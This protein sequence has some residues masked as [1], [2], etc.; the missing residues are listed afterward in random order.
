MKKCI[1]CLGSGGIRGFTHIGVL[2]ALQEH[3][4][5]V[6][7]YFGTSVGSLV[8]AFAA[9]GLSAL[10]IEKK[11]LS[12]KP[13]QLLDLTFPKNGFIKGEKLKTYIEE[14]VSQKNIE[15]LKIPVRIIATNSKTGTAVIFKSGLISERVQASCAIPNIFRPTQIDGVEYLDGDLKSPVPMLMA[16]DEFKNE[17]IVGVN[18]IARTDQA[19]RNHRKWS[20]WVAKDMYRRSLVDH[21]KSAADIYMDIDIGYFGHIMGDWPSRQIE[22]GYQETLKIIPKLKQ[23]LVID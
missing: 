23:L 20:R 12:I 18:I 22:I 8:S 21:E 15:D 11:A 6:Q 14:N 2:K 16:R 9:S 17:I 1:L 4:I 19:P 10:E 13:F 5:N 7:A 3:Q